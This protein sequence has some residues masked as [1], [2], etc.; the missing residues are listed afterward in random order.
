MR[1]LEQQLLIIESIMRDVGIY[2]HQHPRNLERRLTTTDWHLAAAIHTMITLG[3]TY[4]RIGMAL[5]ITFAT[6]S[7]YRHEA[8]NNLN[9]VFFGAAVKCYRKSGIESLIPHENEMRIA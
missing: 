7:A 6:V 4:D 8:E 3:C 9:C 2:T 5:N 1:S